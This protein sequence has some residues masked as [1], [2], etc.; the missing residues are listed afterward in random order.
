MTLSQSPETSSP[1]TSGQQNQVQ[2]D[3]TLATS[4]ALQPRPPPLVK[5]KRNQPRHGHSQAV[6]KVDAAIS[7]GLSNNTSNRAKLHKSNNVPLTDTDTGPPRATTLTMQEEPV[8]ER[9]QEPTTNKAPMSPARLA[10]GAQETDLQ[11]IAGADT[12]IDETNPW[13]DRNNP[14]GQ[15]GTRYSRAPTVWRRHK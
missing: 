6:R 4:E 9:V 12:W 1:S 11:S 10:A 7:P 15:T 14:D 2:R 8:E 3:P 13:K 5:T